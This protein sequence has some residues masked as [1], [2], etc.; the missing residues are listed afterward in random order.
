MP[1][2]ISAHFPCG[3]FHMASIRL[4]LIDQQ[5]TISFIAPGHALKMAVACCARNPD[6]ARSMIGLL[7]EFDPA[8]A[9][10]LRNAI[11]E[12]QTNT[13]STAVD[14][15]VVQ[16]AADRQ[17]SLEPADAGVVLFNLPERRIVQLENR[18]GEL[19]REDRGRMRRNGRP[20][21]VFYNYEL[22]EEWSIV[23]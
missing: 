5:E 13:E 9:E 2:A 3:R 7:G 16:D 6:T 18:F 20:V 1:F 10:A 11:D 23:P 19:Q 21:Q 12:R 8:L 4:T 17:R 15:F 22:P 14:P